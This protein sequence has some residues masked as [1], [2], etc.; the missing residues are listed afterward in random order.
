M[1]PGRSDWRADR[2]LFFLGILHV[3]LAVRLRHEFFDAQLGS[4]EQ[5]AAFFRE[6]HAALKQRKR[7][8]ERQVSGF[9]FFNCG[10]QFAEE[11]F[12]RFNR[13]R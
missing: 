9:E 10:F 11:L 3:Q 5:F 12:K 1:S 6:F 7:L 8:V 4:I 2:S 13:F